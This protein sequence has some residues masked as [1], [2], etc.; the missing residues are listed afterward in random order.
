MATKSVPHFATQSRTILS[1]SEKAPLAQVS[2]EQPAPSAARMTVSVIVR[3]KTPL[4]AAHSRGERRLTRAEFNANHAADPAAIKLVKAFAAEFGLKVE[5]GTPAPGR[6]TMKLTGTV[7]NMQRAFGVSL[8]H[9]TMEGVTYRVREGSIHLPA[10]LQ[11]YVVAVLGLDNRPQAKPHFRVLGELDAAAA[12]TARSQGFARAHAANGS[13]SY[14]PVQVG[15]LYHFPKDASASDQTIG[16]IELGGGFRQKDITAYFNSLDRD[17]PKVVAVPV[18]AGKN[19][20]GTADGADGEVM[21]DIEVAGAIAP[22]ARIVVYFAPNTDQGLC[23]C[24]SRTPFTTPP[25][26]PVVIS[27]SLGLGRKST[28]PPRPWPRSTRHANRRRRSASPSPR[29]RATTAPPTA[30]NDGKNHV[31]FPASSPHVLACGGTNLQGS[32]TSITA[33]RSGTPSR[34]AA[35]PA[36]ASA[37]SSRC[38][39]GRPAPRSPNPPQPQR[40]SRR[41]RRMRRRDPASGY[42]VRVDGK[43]LRDRRHQ[44][45]RAAVG[46][47]DR[48]GQPD[49]TANPP[50]SSSR[51]F[52]PPRQSRLPRHREGR[53][54]QLHSRSGLGSVHGPRFA[55]RLATDPG[56]QTRLVHRGCQKQSRYAETIDPHRARHRDRMFRGLRTPI[57]EAFGMQRRTENS[58][59]LRG[60]FFQ[61]DQAGERA[62]FAAS[63]P[64]AAG[65]TAAS[66]PISTAGLR[67]SRDRSAGTPVACGLAWRPA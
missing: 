41:S 25:T 58:L 19:S 48:R 23:R 30:V 52:M 56:G 61:A 44:R 6:R 51:P 37:T 39:H 14:T 64:R 21:L 67:R 11:G 5:A 35:Q 49:R 38:R 40:R 22:G 16:I 4:S 26:S 20:P 13:I 55:D 17:P 7:A 33:R 54:W 45:R 9:K 10:E 12:K 36:A 47:T 8:A 34:R 46:G 32:G 60:D 31:D 57:P 24:R 50:A 42:I 18:G 66:P 15:Q 63:D 2:G 1:G 28:G 59:D 3:R 53:Q 62:D 43:T 27:I 65:T 29:P